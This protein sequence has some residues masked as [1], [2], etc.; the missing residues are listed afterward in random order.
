LNIDAPRA[1]KEATV[2][3]IAIDLGSRESQICRRNAAGDIVEERRCETSALEAYLEGQAPAVVIVE[4][5]TEAFRVA[6]IAQRYG[7]NA[8]IV[9]GSLVQSL[10][11][12]QRG[13]KN[14]VRDAR[15]L[16]EASCRMALPSVHLPSMQSREW[17]AL[18]TSREALVRTRTQLI[19]GVR[20]YVRSRLP[21][22]PRATPE[23][24]PRKVRQLLLE[25]PIGLPAHL[26]RL[27]VTLECLNEQI[28]AA[29]AELKTL[30]REDERTRRLM[31]VPGV[32]PVT[33]V[34]FVAAVDRVERFPNAARL[35]SYLGLIPGERTTGFRTR[36]T[37][38]TRAGAPQVR[39]ALGQAAWS[40][41]LRRPEDPMVR[42]ARQVA[43]RRGPHVAIMALARKLAH[44]LYAL[45]K[46]HATYDPL[47]LARPAA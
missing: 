6:E 32:G 3:H 12:G 29:D 44:V 18:C 13:L 7:H 9:S 26:D 8:R 33:A 23:T 31:T 38:L 36:R 19:S 14:D 30:A 28:A 2:D 15:A 39:W 43:A 20:S 41:Y 22:R 4:A 16:S 1:R 45:W 40:L 42:W 27:L 24:L 25:S 35:A 46:H 11:V 21:Q 10:G 17:R 47:R 37:H 5:S 34:R